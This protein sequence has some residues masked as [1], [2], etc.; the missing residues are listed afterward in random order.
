MKFE[1]HKDEHPRETVEWARRLLSSLGIFPVEDK[2]FAFTKDCF[3]VSLADIDV[4]FLHVNGK[5]VS[6]WLTLASGYGEFMERLQTGFL[7]PK[8]YGLREERPFYHPDEVLIRGDIL[9]E[10]SGHA[11]APL[12]ASHEDWRMGFKNDLQ[13]RCAPFYSVFENQVVHLPVDLLRMSVGSN[14]ACAGNTPEE[15]LVHGL[16]EILERF[17]AR[18]IFLDGA[19]SLPDIPLERFR[20][21]EVY[22]LMEQLMSRGYELKVKDCSLGGEFPVVGL[23]LNPKGEGSYRLKLGADPVLQVAL[24]RC[25]TE[26]FQ[27]IGSRQ[28][29]EFRA[30]YP[31]SQVDGGGKDTNAFFD[32]LLPVPGDLPERIVF[33]SPGDHALSAFQEGFESHREALKKLV[34]HLHEMGHEIYVRDVSFLGFPTYVVYIPHMSTIFPL[35]RAT[36]QID[37]NER[38]FLRHCL[39]QIKAAS[40]SEIRRCVDLLEGL[41]SLPY[42]RHRLKCGDLFTSL[43][44]T[45]LTL[46][47]AIQGFDIEPLL[48]FLFLKAKEVERARQCLRSYLMKNEQSIGPGLAEEILASILSFTKGFERL[49]WPACGDCSACPAAERCL[50][51]QWRVVNQNIVRTMGQNFPRQE[52]LG[53]L[54]E[55]L[56]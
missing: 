39:L 50:Y 38:P 30:L 4:P 20:S 44:D 27:G 34:S 13:L 55:G 35:D 53:D 3:S 33:D 43:T 24:Q 9:M 14:G 23:V 37:M 7:V 45:W 22:S 47:R 15:A 18:R 48:S 11:I 42:Y 54:F 26:T 6:K 28:Q 21:M 49:P 5:G 12:F 51:P 19:L 31:E 10:K 8:D 2:W 52:D 17:V 36:F 56:S 40:T 41:T 29:P 25:I 1:T 46:A 32:H 16:C